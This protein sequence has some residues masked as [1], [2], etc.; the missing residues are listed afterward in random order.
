MSP[1]PTASG[2]FP[3]PKAS[4]VRTAARLDRPFL[5]GFLLTAGG[6]SALVLGIALSN[7]ST[8]LVS[9]GFAV[10]LA[11]GLEPLVR[12]LVRRGV[13][14]GWAVV[15]VFGLVIL[16]VAGVIAIVLPTV[17]GQL[18]D[19]AHSVPDLIRGF[20]RS[21]VFRFLEQNLGD[22]FDSVV[23]DV[24]S[25]L[26]DPGNILAI[27]GGALQVGITIASVVSSTIIVVVL[28]LYFV[29]TLPAI[30]RAAITL[31]AARRRARVAELADRIAESVGGYL[32]GMALL[33]LCNAVFVF[34][35]HLILRL[36]FPQLMAV[37]AFCITLIPLVG[38][39]LY[40]VMAAVL[41]LFSDP[42]AAL[43]FAVVYLIYM[44]LEAYLLTP[45][46]MSRTIAVPGS[47]VIIGALVGGTLLGLLGALVAIP[48]TAAILLIVREV[49]IPRQD[50]LT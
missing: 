41:A 48:V 15:I 32:S 4:P 18:T 39:V 24:Q 17:I 25:F 40:G 22:G 49:W 21:E 28:T 9:I 37:L 7:L 8:V 12:A 50:A 31:I 2:P 16:F 1:T 44:Q 13:P 19:F 43:I 47:L 6:L 14:R 23:A 38:S 33:A 27:S 30:K 5:I 34:V 20:Q 35:L 3:A 29:A 11:L 45:R 10:F 46:V 26:T 42:T 36:P